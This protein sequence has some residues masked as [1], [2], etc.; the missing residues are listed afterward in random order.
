MK[1]SLSSAVVAA[2]LSIVLLPVSPAA[3]GAAPA[4]AP[5]V[6]TSVAAPEVPADWQERRSAVAART[7]IGHLPA[8]DG[9]RRALDPDDYECSPTALDEYMGGLLAAF[10]DDELQFL[11]TSGVLEFPTY[12]ALLFGS[13][14]DPRYALVH[15]YRQQLS[16]TFRTA[17]RFW[18][19]ESG[20]IQL[21]AMHGEGVLQD[22]GRLARLLEVAYGLPAQAAADYAAYVVAV[23]SQI[24]E[25]RGGSNPLLTLNAYAFTGEGQPDPLISSIPDRIVMG[26]GILDFFE[27]LGIAD[28]GA[29]SVLAHEFAHHV[30]FEN[31][32]F[33]SP[34]T[35]AEATRRTELMAD[36][37]GTYFATHSRGLTLNAKRVLR[38]VET[39][40]VV[41]DC[42]FDDVNHHGTP[43]QRARAAQWGVDLADSA[44]KQGHVLP[45]L[46]VAGR[47]DDALPELVAPDAR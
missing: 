7:G 24:P 29:R 33:D 3:A 22:A 44:Q 21:M 28:T 26:D 10:D 47:F 9:A 25:L 20:D 13:A 11:L 34:L 31:D 38:A 41:G 18:D 12:D 27:H 23:V 15:E 36:A 42:S 39:F 5:V 19:V 4:A 35:G 6:A 1:T 40:Q 16:G 46:T 43:A 45:S 17:Q 14:T 30:Q 8:Q 37:L 32:L 2:G